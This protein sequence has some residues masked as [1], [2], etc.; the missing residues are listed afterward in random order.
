[1]ADP[2]NVA[3]TEGDADTEGLRVPETDGLCVQVLVGE[4]GRRVRVAEIVKDAE[5]V[6]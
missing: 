4:S 5:S 6:R 1:V 2:E 3:D